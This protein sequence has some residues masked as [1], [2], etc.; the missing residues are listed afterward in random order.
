M[1]WLTA[2]SAPI[3]QDLFNTVA[4]KKPAIG[5]TVRVRLGK[6]T[7]KIGTVRKH[8]VSRYKH[9]F[10]Y[11]NEA[12]HAMC[13]ARGR[14]G[15]VVLVQPLDGGPEFWVDADDKIMLCVEG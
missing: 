5:A 10:R 9:P 6:H 7:G 15:Y 3:F 13:Q 2:E 1:P 11:G 12:S 14:Y 4:K 8:I